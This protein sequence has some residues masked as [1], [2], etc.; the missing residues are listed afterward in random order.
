VP[1]VHAIETGPETV[2]KACALRR[3]M[4]TPAG[5]KV[6][7]FNDSASV[8]PNALFTDAIGKT[9]PRRSDVGD[10]SKDGSA[11]SKNW[12]VSSAAR[13]LRGHGQ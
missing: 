3:L 4:L 2:Q 10:A 6:L 11:N 13:D 1:I 12:D 7:E 9:D 5:P 8:T